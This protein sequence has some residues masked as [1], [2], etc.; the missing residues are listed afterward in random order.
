M[1]NIYITP[2]LQLKLG[3]VPAPY[4]C[5][6]KLSIVLTVCDVL[7]TNLSKLSASN[8]VHSRRLSD[9][10]HS[11]HPKKAFFNFIAL[12]GTEPEQGMF[13]HQPCAMELFS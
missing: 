13:K 3:V 4:S 2:R 7:F 5:V 1:D 6:L 10:I 8:R 11:R 9:S 12:P